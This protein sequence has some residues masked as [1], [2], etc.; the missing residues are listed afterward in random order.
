LRHHGVL[1]VA[2][3]RFDLEIL[4]D[5]FEEQLDLPSLL[6]NVGDRFCRPAKLVANEEIVFACFRIAVADA[7]EL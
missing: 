2:Q 1:C 3:K 4:F 5:P 6:I 7:A